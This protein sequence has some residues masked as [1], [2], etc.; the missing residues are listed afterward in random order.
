MAALVCSIALIVCALSARCAADEKQ[1]RGGNSRKEPAMQAD[2]AGD[3]L[4]IL[5]MEGKDV[6]NARGRLRFVANRIERVRGTTEPPSGVIAVFPLE[7]G[8]YEVFA[9]KGKVD[10]AQKLYRYTT[11]DFASYSKGRK[12]LDGLRWQHLGGGKPVYT[13]HDSGDV[14]WSAEAKRF[15]YTQATYQRWKKLYPDNIGSGMRRVL[16]VRTSADGVRWR[17]AKGVGFGAPHRPAAELF[18]PDKQ[19]PPEVE[20]Y[21]M[22]AFRYG[23]RVVGAMLLYAPSPQVVNPNQKRGTPDF[24]PGRRP[25]K[26][27]PQLATEWWVTDKSDDIRAWRRPYR[28]QDA[29]P[30][31]KG[32]RHVPVVFR[33]RLLWLQSSGGYGVPLHRI[34]GVYSRANG[35]FSTR[36]FVMPKRPLRLNAKALWHGDKSDGQQRQAYIMV[37]VLDEKDKPIA[38]FEKEKCIF[39]DKDGLR[40][41]LRWKGRDAAALAGRTVS[42]RFYFRDATI[43]AVETGAAAR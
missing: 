9:W 13:D 36:R 12:V 21:R 29:A 27:G 7:K 5:T 28:E 39:L 43:Y 35:E 11:S 31:G 41:P 10:K 22:Q 14:F 33:D 4:L 37:E 23:D 25:S 2:E 34:A 19:D 30:P 1:P 40:L 38:G 17:P 20:F 24:R 18:V 8:G 42:M 32:I 16:S 6:R 15:V 26:H 3:R